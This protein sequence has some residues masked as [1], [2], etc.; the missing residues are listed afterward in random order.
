F[1]D[2]V[3]AAVRVRDRVHHDPACPRR[4]RRHRH[5]LLYVVAGRQPRRDRLR[6]PGQRERAALHHPHQ[7]VRCRRGQQGDAVQA[8]VRPHRRLPQLHHLLD[9]LHDR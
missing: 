7:R 1:H 4:L 5:H 3:E 9:T 2:P 8:M 6:V